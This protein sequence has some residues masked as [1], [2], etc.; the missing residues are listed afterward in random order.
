VNIKTSNF[1]GWWYAIDNDTYDRADDGN[2]EQGGGRTE[3]EAIDDLK[4]KL[5]ELNS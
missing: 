3:Q 4:E 5:D 1:Y 2:N